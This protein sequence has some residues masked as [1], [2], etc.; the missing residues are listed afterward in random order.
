VHGF[1][2]TGLDW[3]D[4]TCEELTQNTVNDKVKKKFSLNRRSGS[5]SIQAS[6]FITRLGK[7]NGLGF[8]FAF[9]ETRQA[10]PQELI[11]SR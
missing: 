5:Y 10:A 9:S 1:I 2:P 7:N 6:W 8:L 11:R 3:L 4:S